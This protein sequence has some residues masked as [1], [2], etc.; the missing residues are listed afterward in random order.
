[1]DGTDV[2]YYLNDALVD[3]YDNSGGFYTDGNIFFG[4]TDPF[5]SA[6]GG[7]RMILDNV[8]VVVPEPSTVALAFL[9]GVGLLFLARRRKQ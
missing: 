2:N 8:M 6:N 1:V 7:N 5:N 3:T 9:G 4:L